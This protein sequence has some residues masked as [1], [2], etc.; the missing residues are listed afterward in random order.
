MSESQEAL[1]NAL[2]VYDE[3]SASAHADYVQFLQASR[4]FAQSYVDA[5]LER[6]RYQNGALEVLLALLEMARRLR[7]EAVQLRVS[8]KRGPCKQFKCI[9]K[10]GKASFFRRWRWP[11]L[12]YLLV[13]VSIVSSK[14]LPVDVDVFKGIDFS[15]RDILAAYRLLDDFWVTEVQNLSQEIQTVHVDRVRVEKWLGYKDTLK[16]LI[17]KWRVRLSAPCFL[18]GLGT[19]CR[20][21]GY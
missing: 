2:L 12:M 15:L 21:E 7:G 18:S 8:F 17:S 3:A 14:P 1:P 6:M 20:R 11:T 5:V 4:D 19:K 13:S 9:I 16:E 10:E